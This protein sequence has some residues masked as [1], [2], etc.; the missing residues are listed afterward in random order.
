MFTLSPGEETPEP[1][2]A[3]KQGL[4]IG[5][6]AGQWSRQNLITGIAAGKKVGAWE[7]G[8]IGKTELSCWSWVQNQGG[9]ISIR[10]E[11]EP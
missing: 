9:I 6:K 4:R 1:R 10:S 7:R 11:S 3:S 5:V 8:L 2:E